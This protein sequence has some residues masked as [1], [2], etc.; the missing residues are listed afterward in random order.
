MAHKKYYKTLRVMLS[1]KIFL[2]GIKELLEEILGGGQK[3]EVFY[4]P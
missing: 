2:N 3:L 4:Y 1:D